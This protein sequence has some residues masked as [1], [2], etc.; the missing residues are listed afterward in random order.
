LETYLINPKN[1]LTAPTTTIHD[2]HDDSMNT[3]KQLTSHLL[4]TVD[5]PAREN[6][7]RASWASAF[8]KAPADRRSFSGG[9]SRPS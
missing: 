8:A 9:W 3:K 1:T 5:D 4:N 6:P 7:S 2:E